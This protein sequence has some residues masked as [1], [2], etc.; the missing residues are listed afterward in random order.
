[1]MNAA[2]A[3]NIISGTE[4]E[5]RAIQQWLTQWCFQLMVQSK[6]HRLDQSPEGAFPP[7]GVG[8]AQG[9]PSQGVHEPHPQAQ[10]ERHEVGR[11]QRRRPHDR[12]RAV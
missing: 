3:D 10:A 8:T 6:V 9:A 4:W 5:V 11:R 7:G 2:P 12:H 1:M